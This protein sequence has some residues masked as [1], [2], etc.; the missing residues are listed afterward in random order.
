MRPV[1]TLF[2]LV[3]LVACG[4]TPYGETS[5]AGS[6]AGDAS[7][8]SIEVAPSILDYGEVPCGVEPAAKLIAIHNKGSGPSAYKVQISEGTSF[9]VDGAREGVLLPGATAA[10]SVFVTPRSGGESSTDL[11]VS[12][13]NVLQA[14]HARVKG[15]GA[16]FELVDS[17]VS[18]GDVRKEN[19]ALPVEV[20]VRNPGT[21][22]V[23]VSTLLVSDAA[24]AVQ[25]AAM[26][27]ALTVAPGGSSRFSVTMVSAAVDD[28]APLTA[29]VKPKETSF[30]GAVPTL[31]LT[32]RRVTSDVTV[33]PA[34]WGKQGCSTT[35]SARN[36][37]ITNY[38]TAVVTYSLAPAAMS[39]FTILDEGPLVIAAGT[40]TAPATATLKVAPKT[41]PTTAPLPDIKELLKVQLASSA[42]GVSGSRAVPLHVEVRGAIVTIN[43]P[44]LS[45]NST[46]VVDRR[47][48]T[49]A[50]AG[51]ESV[52]FNWAFARTPPSGG[53]PWAFS[54]PGSVAAGATANGS[55]DFTGLQQGLS[56][57]TL[58]PSQPFILNVPECKP[59]GILAL[60]GTRP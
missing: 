39:A 1:T 59:M 32:G 16:R 29:T 20:E 7:F 46:G 60:S 37:V 13:G 40:P 11:F 15:T 26:P 38:A 57:A 4:S 19:G 18:F 50:N 58:K 5:D 22:P 49:V 25:W 9:R 44:S 33:S 28:A 56:T 36:I 30:C 55:V 21:A 17:S 41:L 34:D 48:F 45:F 10:L 53:S 8:G 6:G 35:P 43:P 14:V 52:Y 23:S 3:V 27:A 31:T 2:S 42:P 54:T 24:F 12:A 51:N 47:S